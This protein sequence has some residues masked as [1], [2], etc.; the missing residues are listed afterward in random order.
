MGRPEGGSR[1]ARI[2]AL[3]VFC[4]CVSIP[5]LAGWNLVTTPYSWATLS[6]AGGLVV[7]VV[8]TPYVLRFLYKVTVL[9]T[10]H[11]NGLVI[12]GTENRLWWLGNYMR[13]IT[14]PYGLLFIASVFG[15]RLTTSSTKRA[16]AWQTSSIV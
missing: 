16:S 9:S 1:A 13:T 4:G 10:W 6:W 2:T 3:A 14:V 5:L 8:A 15:W 12:D 7:G 11:R